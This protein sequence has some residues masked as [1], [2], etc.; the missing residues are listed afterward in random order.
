MLTFAK[1]EHWESSYA[2]DR[3]LKTMSHF[4]NSLGIT[5]VPLMFKQTTA[6]FKNLHTYI[7]SEHFLDSP[8]FKIIFKP[9]WDINSMNIKITTML[10]KYN[11]FS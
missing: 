6:E 7:S 3:M 1:E 8:L 4:Q 2:C 9:L 10:P 5:Y 11:M